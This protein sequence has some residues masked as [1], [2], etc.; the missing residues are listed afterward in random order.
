M[1]WDNR[2]R[3][4]MKLNNM[5]KKY[6]SELKRDDEFDAKNEMI[7]LDKSIN[8][9]ENIIIF[10]RNW[11]I[12]DKIVNNVFSEI[13]KN[14]KK[15]KFIILEIS[16]NLISRIKIIYRNIFLDIYMNIKKIVIV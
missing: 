4:F 6:L 3:N 14:R 12:D 5:I 9:Y 8:K 2:I 16:W 7:Y 11:E 13:N 15:S 10:I 1:I